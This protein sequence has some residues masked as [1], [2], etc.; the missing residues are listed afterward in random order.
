MPESKPFEDMR[1]L[2]ATLPEGD[3]AAALRTSEQTERESAF[4]GA[5]QLREIAA[6]LSRWSRKSPPRVDRPMLALFAG[7]HGV[8]RHGVSADTDAVVAREVAAISSGQGLLSRL[9]AQANVGLKVL[10]LALD[11]PTGDISVEPALDERACAATMAFGM[12]AVAGG[13]DLLCLSALGAAGDTAARSLFAALHGGAGSDWSDGALASHFRMRQA[14]VIDAA[15]S[16]H[17]VALADPF[18]LLRRLGGREIAAICG[19]ILAARIERVPIVLDGLPALAAAHVLGAANTDAVSHCL[20]AVL[21]DEDAL[22]EAASL[23]GL[24]SVLGRRQ[25]AFPGVNGLLAMGCAR[26]STAVVSA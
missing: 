6:W 2:I 12:E 7:A 1:D 25:A 8:S 16:A 14:A 20:L 9:C 21:P 5:G 17:R 15:L 4:G 19:A 23:N 11:L 24:E 3:D 13:H 10:D 18:E 22:S 26:A